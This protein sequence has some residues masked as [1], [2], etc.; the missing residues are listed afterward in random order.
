MSRYSFKI[1]FFKFF[2]LIFSACFLFFYLPL[3]SN[4]F[5]LG[6]NAYGAMSSKFQY[7]NKLKDKKQDITIMDSELTSNIGNNKYYKIFSR[8]I[9]K[10]QHDYLLEEVIGEYKLNE[11]SITLRAP[12]AVVDNKNRKIMFE[13]QVA[14]TS[15]GVKFLSENVNIDLKNNLVYSRDNFVA[16]YQN[17]EIKAKQFEIQEKHL[18]KFKG[19]VS[20]KIELSNFKL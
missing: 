12:C 2:L 11:G 10:I 1:G 19:N 5:I 16:T 9:Y 6:K 20:T 7:I 3:I 18:I 13:N 15:G 17:S 8:R 14:L 4:L